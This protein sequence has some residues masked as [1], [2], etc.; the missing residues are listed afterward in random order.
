MAFLPYGMSQTVPFDRNVLLRP[1][2]PEHPK[3]CTFCMSPHVGK[4]VGNLYRA[5]YY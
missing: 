4:N 5:G 1:L 2:G 3:S